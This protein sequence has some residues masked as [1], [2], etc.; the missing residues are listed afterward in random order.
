LTGAEASRVEDALRAPWRAAPIFLL[1]TIV[2]T[3]PL[4]F[5]L[6]SAVPAGF[7]DLWQN[8]WNFWWW[9]KCL[10]EGHD[11]YWTSHLFHPT[12]VAL[13]FHTHSAF[14]MLA[15]LPVNLL[16]G[17][18][19]AYNVCVLFAVWLSGFGAY[20]LVRELTGS[21]RAGLL[22]G[23]VFAFFPQHLEQTLEH[24]NL[25]STGFLPLALFAFVRLVRVGGRRYCL[26]LGLFFALNALADWHLALKA[27]LVLAALTLVAFFRPPR[28]RAAL[29]RDLAGAGLVAALLTLPA[30]APL[31]QAMASKSATFQKPPEDRGIDAAFLLRPHF[32]HPLW[33]GLTR[34]AYAERRAYPA[35]GFVSYLGFVPLALAGIALV[36][37]PREALLPAA[38]FASSLVFALGAHPF[39]DGRLQEWITL[40]FAL[41]ERVPIL[42]L[43]RIANRFLVIT[44]LAL[45]VLTGVGFT[46]LRRRSDVVFATLVSLL[47]L[48]Y[49]WLPYPMREDRLSPLYARLRDE[50]P[51]GAV[52]DL[53]FS[54]G[55][56]TVQN[57]RAQTIHG[58][59]IAGGYVSVLPEAA[60]Q[61][62]AKDPALAD[63]FGISPRLRQ[64]IDRAHLAGLGFGVAV[65]HKDRRQS[66]AKR[67]RLALD[68]DDL[69][70]HRIAS[71]SG[72]VPDLKFGALRR[73]LK[74]ACGVPLFEDN[75]IAVFDLTRA[76]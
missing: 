33:G 43:L 2:L 71:R 62:I 1:L 47:V 13:V 53:P 24:L 66:F 10:L 55:A 26:W 31:M 35:A 34:E 8:V 20:L 45:A 37:R 7:A 46:A 28:P 27:V 56:S 49:L 72:G 5:R 70:A 44:S 30:A 3:Y 61:A 48:D 21:A 73:A 39:W 59:P 36:R 67:Q 29:A 14:N 18:E 32:H 4:A 23:I 57:M 6:T 12:G 58:R 74:D 17:P 16:L 75:E 22:G 50:A 41:L 11:P 40:P 60:L 65:F 42:S 64:P 69:F 68:P 51:K 63:L 38:F 54:Q 76:P 19:A 52:L 9:K 25:F 15:S